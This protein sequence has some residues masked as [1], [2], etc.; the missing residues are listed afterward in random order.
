V[1]LHVL[2]ACGSWPGPGD[3]TSGYLLADSGVSLVVDLGTGTFARLQQ[4]TSPHDLG[5]VVVTHAHPDHFVD[6]YS[7]FYSR[8][9]HQEPLPPLPLFAPPGA[10]D[11]ITSYAPARRKEEFR[12]VFDIR[13]IAP[14]DT[15]ETGPFR[16]R[17]HEM[18]HQPLTIGLRISAGPA[19]LAYTADTGA[20]DEVIELARGAETLLCDATWLS[21]DPRAPN[22][23]SPRQ[24]AG[25]AAGAGVP[26]LLLTHLWPSVPP[27][28]AIAEARLGF[29]GEVAVARSGLR[30]PIG[31]DE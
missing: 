28:G 3:A 8:F 5:A 1:N 9:F 24:A 25:Y 12:A 17:A 31:N 7:L 29:N 10:F 19:T 15:V 23:L 18:L 26:R 2:G 22:H 16:L 11:A 30:M 6:L 4:V 21:S 27:E 13:T 20:T 14:G